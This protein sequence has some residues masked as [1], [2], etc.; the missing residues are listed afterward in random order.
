[1][2]KKTVNSSS[3][4]NKQSTYTLPPKHRK[5]GREVLA[6]DPG[7]SGAIV[8]LNSDGGFAFFK[9]PL[10]EEGISFGGIQSILKD[11]SD[12]PI[13]LERAIPFKMGTKHAFS[14]GR[15]F[16]FIEIAVQL[17]GNAVTYVEP[18]KW[19]KEMHQ[20]IMK[21]LKSKAKSEIAIKRLFPNLI[22]Q[23][24]HGPKSKKI[25]EGVMDA[26]LIAG[27]ALRKLGAER[28]DFF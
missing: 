3:I 13:F 9:M 18:G 28:E 21:D 23:I 12:V 26:V 14:Y 1:M 17:S 27:Y 8:Y 4:E 6:V 20:G 2:R 16:G 5:P 10:D 19:T 11:F 22:K 15:G 25:D 24:P 7:N